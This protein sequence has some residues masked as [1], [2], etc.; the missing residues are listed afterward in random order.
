[1]EN[2]QCRIKSSS[3]FAISAFCL[4][5]YYINIKKELGAAAAVDKMNGS[6]TYE[7]NNFRVKTNNFTIEYENLNASIALEEGFGFN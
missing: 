2:G 5:F 1:M 7:M 3:I 6:T 4:V